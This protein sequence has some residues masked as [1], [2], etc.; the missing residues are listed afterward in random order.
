LPCALI[1]APS[2]DRQIVVREVLVLFVATAAVPLVLIDGRVSTFESIALLAFA[3]GYTVVMIWTS[4]RGSAAT[5]DAVAGDAA[6]ATS[7]F[8]LCS[9]CAD[10]RRHR[11]DTRDRWR[12][13][14]PVDAVLDRSDDPHAEEHAF[15]RVVIEVAPGIYCAIL[16]RW[17][18]R[19][20]FST[21]R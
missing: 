7:C 4:R 13:H 15:R 12:V 9:H 14:C 17:L 11:C 8:C 6:E 16:V 20:R 19:P 10:H 2:V 18:Q 3:V 21:R 1:R 5:A